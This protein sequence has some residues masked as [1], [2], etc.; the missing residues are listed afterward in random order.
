MNIGEEIRRAR[1]EKKLTQPE[2]AKKCGWTSQSRIS[3]YE[4]GE[5]EPSYA[6]LR[7]ISKV[8]DVSLSR[9]LGSSID[10]TPAY[11]VEQGVPIK[12]SVPLINW[13]QAG[14]WSEIVD[15]YVPTEGEG[16]VSV[17]SNIGPRSFALTVQGD[18]MEP[19]FTDGSRIVID[20]DSEPS[21]KSFV[22]ARLDSEQEA[23][24]KQIIF[25]GGRC[26]LKPLNPRYPIIE[27][28][29][30]MSIVGVVKEQSKS[31]S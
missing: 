20:P 12:R 21:D 16:K 19:E 6:D 9:F 17:D 15:N 2:L 4:R 30:D 24:F 18:S 23:T 11:S 5:R 7:R 8:L 26:Y 25:D 22:I 14:Q 13:V 29:G 27:A 10:P 1:K 3:M 31:Y 28:T